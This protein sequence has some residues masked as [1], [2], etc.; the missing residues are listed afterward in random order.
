MGS[1]KVYLLFLLMQTLLPQAP[2][3]AS[4]RSTGLHFFFS[5]FSFSF[6]FFSLFFSLFL[7][8]S[9]FYLFSFLSSFNIFACPHQAL[10]RNK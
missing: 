6:F 7:F 3:T 10:G 9:I 4:T 2:A 5:S 8:L 1:G